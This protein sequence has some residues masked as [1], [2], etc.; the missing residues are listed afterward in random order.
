[1]QG[2]LPHQRF[3]IDLMAC[4]FCGLE[5][6][7]DLARHT[8]KEAD[9]A[10]A[11]PEKLFSLGMF[12][13]TVGPISPFAVSNQVVILFIPHFLPLYSEGRVVTSFPRC[14]DINS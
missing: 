1:M 11:F 7:C 8:I 14:H 5:P 6:Y 3:P 10:V 13:S 12:R 4:I 2:I 9:F